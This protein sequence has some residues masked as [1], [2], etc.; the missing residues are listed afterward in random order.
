[1]D[2]VEGISTLTKKLG[3][4]LIQFS[5]KANHNPPTDSSEV[6]LKTKIDA[7]A[8]ANDKLIEGLSNLKN[9]P[10]YLAL[11]TAIHY[12]TDRFLEHLQQ[13]YVSSYH[14][15]STWQTDFG[16]GFFRRT[17]QVVIIFLGCVLVVYPC[18]TYLYWMCRGNNVWAKDAFNGSSESHKMNANPLSFFME[19]MG[20]SIW[21]LSNKTGAAVIKVV[22]EQSDFKTVDSPVNS[23]VSYTDFLARIESLGKG[24][25]NRT[26]ASPLYVCYCAA[27]EYFKSHPEHGEKITEYTAH[28]K[29]DLLKLSTS[30]TSTEP[31]DPYGTLA[32]HVQGLL[33]EVESIKT[34][35]DATSFS[36][37]ALTG[38]ILGS[39]AVGGA[40]AAVAF[41]AGTIATYLQK[42]IPFLKKF[43]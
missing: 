36:G 7:V 1:M 2:I 41:K 29:E 18:L 3:M 33:S 11:V 24:D 22:S 43:L 17:D 35:S 20:F 21:R 10:L 25:V 12:G 31:A 5:R 26:E 37:G 39:A 19:A 34:L 32:E 30:I 6:G 14:P 27:Y 13:G 28:I 16:T 40:G 4:L 38:S 42:A 8:E 9:K 15:G 23:A